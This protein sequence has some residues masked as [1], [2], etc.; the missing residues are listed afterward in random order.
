MKNSVFILFIIVAFTLSAC[1]QLTRVVPTET[2]PSIPTS[3]SSQVT[4]EIASTDAPHLT[5]VPTV[6]PASHPTVVPTVMPTTNP[7]FD[8]ATLGDLSKLDSYVLTYTTRFQKGT[9]PGAPEGQVESNTILTVINHPFQAAFT[10]VTTSSRIANSQDGTITNDDYFIGN[11]V[12]QH[13]K[14]ARFWD[15]QK[16][17]ETNQFMF[18]SLSHALTWF[19]PV[20]AGEQDY[21]GIPAYHFVINETIKAPASQN[22]QESENTFTGNV[23]LAKDGNYPLH[24]DYQMSGSNWREANPKAP[25]KY[26][27]VPGSGEFVYEVTSINQ[28]KEIQ[29]PA[30]VPKQVNLAIDVPLPP[31]AEFN[32]VMVK[33]GEGSNRLSYTYSVSLTDD[34]ILDFYKKYQPSADGW[35]VSAAAKD[36]GGSG[37]QIV[38]NKGNK[39]VLIDIYYSQYA[40]V[41]QVK[42]DYTVP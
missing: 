3:G 28:V 14:E 32:D 37:G 8:L 17:N 35:S 27:F 21:H 39:M 38:L 26:I 12:Y 29:F 25:P 2:S 22:S 24:L 16:P 9:Q 33:D 7:V 30:G 6:T 19:K 4:A 42:F 13:N 34:Q 15:I 10:S 31:E 36:P 20:Y 1:G 11:L 40:N 18:T 23:F 41:N 5:V